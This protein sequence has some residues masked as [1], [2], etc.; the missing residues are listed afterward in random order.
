MDFSFNFFLPDKSRVRFRA[1]LH[2]QRGQLAATIRPIPKRITGFEDLNLP[3]PIKSLIQLERGLLLVEK[4]D[5]LEA[6]RSLDQAFL[7]D[8]GLADK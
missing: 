2:M 7:L 8:P 5:F 3:T 6:R 1:N 4:Q